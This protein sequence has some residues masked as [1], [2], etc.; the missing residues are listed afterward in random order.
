M[1]LASKDAY[2]SS[3]LPRGS[4]VGPVDEVMDC[5][6]GRYLIEVRA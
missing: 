6:C 1:W 3:V 2:K 5:A 4:L